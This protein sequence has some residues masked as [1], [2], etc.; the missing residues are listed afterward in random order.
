MKRIISY[1]I[2][3]C[4]LVL[5]P[6]F[7]HAQKKPRIENLPKYDLKPYHF[8][9]LLALN[10][11]D[12]IIKP[13]KNFSSSDSLLVLEAEPQLG[14]NIGIISNLR[15]GNYTDL[16]FLPTLSFG[17]R[18]LEYTIKTDSNTSELTKKKIESTY[19]DFP[20]L[21]KYKSKRLNNVR[22]YIIGGV[23]YSL[24]LASQAKKKQNNL[25]LVRIKSNDIMC[26]IGIGFDFYTEYFKFATEIKMSYGLKDLIVRDNSILTNSIDRLNSKIFQLSFLFE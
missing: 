15:L 11:M 8:G 4:F 3:F 25:S 2:C 12:F 18:I 20:L 23:Q 5:I 13:N 22:S 16:R 24:D 14:F 26:Q 10:Q 6:F 1:I 9:F 17:E 21:F 7:S 19:L